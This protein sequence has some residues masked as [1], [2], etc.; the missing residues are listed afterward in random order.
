MFLKRERER[1]RQKISQR[2]FVQGKDLL[3]VSTGWRGGCHQRKDREKKRKKK[4]KSAKKREKKRKIR[5]ENKMERL[6][7]L[8]TELP[9]FRLRGSQVQT[10]VAKW[11]TK[12]LKVIQ[13][14]LCLKSFFPLFFQGL[15]I[16]N[17][18]LF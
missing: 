9:G 1:E 3:L 4:R 14:F 5:E 17:F 8:C 2:C 13:K 6:A 18:L 15:K 12:K 16:C 7:S 11:Q 10:E